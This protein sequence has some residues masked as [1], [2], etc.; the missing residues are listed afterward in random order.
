VNFFQ[1]FGIGCLAA[2]VLFVIT[3]LFKYSQVETCPKDGEK[4]RR[5]SVVLECPKCKNIYV[6]KLEV[7][8]G[9]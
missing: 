8:N 7:T 4:L 2:T 1:G 5:V 3:L 6:E 9:R